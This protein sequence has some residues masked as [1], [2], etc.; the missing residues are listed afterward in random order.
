MS[1]RF[2]A[3]MDRSPRKPALALD[4]V[5]QCRF[6]LLASFAFDA[7]CTMRLPPQC[8]REQQL[9]KLHVRHADSL[10]TLN[11][12]L[13]HA[14]LRHAPPF[15]AVIFVCEMNRSAIFDSLAIASSRQEHREPASLTIDGTHAHHATIFTLESPRALTHATA[16]RASSSH[17][18]RL[19]PLAAP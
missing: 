8:R 19:A 14:D 16:S 13:R 3:A 6:V 5:P 7:A 1:C 12:S 2:A 18:S 10:A 11:A 9:R 4:R 17:C 15:A